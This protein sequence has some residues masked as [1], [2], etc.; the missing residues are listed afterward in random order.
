MKKKTL[1]IFGSCP[2]DIKME[3]VTEVLEPHPEAVLAAMEA[4]RL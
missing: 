3:P 2:E 4:A 1:T